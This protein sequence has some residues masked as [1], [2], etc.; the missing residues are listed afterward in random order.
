MLA[1]A[2]TTLHDNSIH[3]EDTFLLRDLGNNE[4]LDAVMDG[5]TNHGGEEASTSVSQALAESPMESPDDIVKVLEELNQEFF[6]VGGGRFLLTT[7]SVALVRDDH[8]WVIS[9][10]DSPV[11]HIIPLP[12]NLRARS[13]VTATPTDCVPP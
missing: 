12:N 7:A 4:F 8:L 1:S 11:Y 5:V 2:V 6:Q 13:P 3:G 9:A 10:G